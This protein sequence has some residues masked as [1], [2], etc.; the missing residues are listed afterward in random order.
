MLL[1][2]LTFYTKSTQRSLLVIALKLLRDQKLFT[3]NPVKMNRP[4]VLV[5]R[6]DIPAAG[7]NLLKE[8]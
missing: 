4:K 1:S 3:S 5:T 7:L 6:P 2:N 8:Q